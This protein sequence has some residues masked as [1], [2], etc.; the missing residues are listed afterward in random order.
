MQL[1]QGVRSPE[2]DNAAHQPE[3]GS[4]AW[5]HATQRSLLSLDAVMHCIRLSKRTVSKWMG[6]HSFPSEISLTAFFNGDT[7]LVLRKPLKQL[8]DLFLFS[9]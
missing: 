8:S 4:T 3:A 5:S 2:E 9:H 7:V 6:I 1:M